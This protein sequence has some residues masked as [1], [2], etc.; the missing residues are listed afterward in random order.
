MKETVR[1]FQFQRY[2]LV[3]LVRPGHEGHNFG[4]ALKEFGLL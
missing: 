1:D 2:A 4:P 3:K